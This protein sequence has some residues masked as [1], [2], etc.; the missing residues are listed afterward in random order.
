MVRTAASRRGS[1]E[2]GDGS[3]CQSDPGAAGRRPPDADEA[4]AARLSTTPDI[5]VVGALCPSSSA[6]VLREL[7]ADVGWNSAGRAI[8]GDSPGS[9]SRSRTDRRVS[10]AGVPGWI[11]RDRGTGTRRAADG[12]GSAGKRV[13]DHRLR[14]ERRPPA[15]HRIRRRRPVQAR[16]RPAPSGP[17]CEGSSPS[18]GCAAVSRR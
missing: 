14:R 11:G 2:W 16:C 18:W 12:I 8:A 4:L 5:V 9:R 10:E 13:A 6:R 3:R 1:R 15:R 17:T 7:R